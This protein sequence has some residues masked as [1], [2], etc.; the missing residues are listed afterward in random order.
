M[1][2]DR[3]FDPQAQGGPPP[4]F[5]YKVWAGDTDP[6]TGYAGVYNEV[7]GWTQWSAITNIDLAQSMS[8][9]Q[10]AAIRNRWV[11]IVSQGADEA[12][13]VELWPDALFPTDDT[14]D[15]SDPAISNFVRSLP[16]W[17]RFYLTD[18]EFPDTRVEAVYWHDINDNNVID[19]GEPTFS[20][21]IVPMPQNAAV[22]VKALFRVG[23]VRAPGMGPEPIQ[24]GW[25]FVEDG[26][27]VDQEP[28]AHTFSPDSE[29]IQFVAAS[30]AVLPDPPYEIQDPDNFLGD[31]DRRRP[32]TYVFR[33]AAFYDAG[34]GLI[35]Q[36]LTPSNVYFTVVPTGVANYIA[37]PDEAD[38]QPFKEQEIE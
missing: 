8:A 14:I 36:D 35:I 30:P 1:R 15:L 12:G 2:L 38:A 10:F 19:A 3:S 11:L 23:V 32:V 22:P 26:I 33:A 13:N 37:P 16:N 17:Q 4:V 9:T 34:G 6:A 27:V 21:P 25:Q 31:P 20:G 18:R 24:V 7:F 5:T 28:D 29:V